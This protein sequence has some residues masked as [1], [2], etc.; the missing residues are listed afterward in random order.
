M[1]DADEKEIASAHQLFTIIY[2]NYV[3]HLSKKSLS[4]EFNI[5]QLTSS[6]KLKS[7]ASSTLNSEVVEMT[8]SKREPGFL[9]SDAGTACTQGT[10]Y[11]S[12]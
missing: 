2:N 6:L 11:K 7:S 9:D 1:Y 12:K 8:L 3:D 5:K 10:N 4:D